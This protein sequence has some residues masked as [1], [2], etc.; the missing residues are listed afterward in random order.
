MRLRKFMKQTT[1]QLGA[2]NRAS[3]SVP[4]KSAAAGETP[5]AALR[6]TLLGA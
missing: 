3:A 1:P 4:R 5:A 6:A 2:P